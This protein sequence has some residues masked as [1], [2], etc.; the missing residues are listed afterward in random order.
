MM[1]S[2][3]DQFGLGTLIGE[4]EFGKVFECFDKKDG[5]K[6]VGRQAQSFIKLCKR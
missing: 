5:K 6:K 4:G 2:E 3:E 1:T